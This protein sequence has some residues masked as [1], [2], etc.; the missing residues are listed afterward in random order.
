[1]EE[2]EHFSLLK[3]CKS[4]FLP[5]WSRLAATPQGEK[6]NFL[7]EAFRKS[8]L[9]LEKGGREGFPGRSFQKAK[10]IRGEGR[11]R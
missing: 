9:P 7:S 3:S 1:M 6:W 8:L 11:L 4:P 2:R 5:L 10:F